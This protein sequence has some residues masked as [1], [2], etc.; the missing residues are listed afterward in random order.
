[1]SVDFSIEYDY[2]YSLSFRIDLFFSI[3]PVNQGWV[4]DRLLKNLKGFQVTLDFF[5]QL[6]II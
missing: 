6:R 4:R 2:T 1:M 3:V 5:L